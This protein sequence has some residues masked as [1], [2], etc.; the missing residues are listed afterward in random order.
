MKHITIFFDFEGKWGM[1]YKSR[2]DLIKTTHCL[3][4]VLDKYSVNAVFFVVGKIIEEYPNL[5][6]E[7]VG[8]GHE[9]AIHGYKHEHLDK[10]T[11]EELIVFSDNLSRIELLLEKL[12]GKRPA[13]FRSPYLMAPKFYTPELYKILEEHGYQWVSNREIRHSDELFRPDRI[14]IISLWGKK[15]WITRILLPLLNMRMILTD[16]ITKKKGFKRLIAN[17]RWLDGGAAPFKR[18]GLLEIPVYTPLDCDLLGLPKPNE[19]TPDDFVSY[20]VATLAGGAER[21]RDF[22]NITFH[23]WI[24]GTANRVSILENTLKLLRSDKNNKIITATE[25]VKLVN[26]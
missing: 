5:I 19:N 22:Y 16:H 13:G 15:N 7:I 9:I 23:D 26:K 11:K 14:K 8:H 24:I 10:L 25:R 4:N 12:I 3:L 21:K 18:Y 2:Y 6:K 17:I 20:A 1:P